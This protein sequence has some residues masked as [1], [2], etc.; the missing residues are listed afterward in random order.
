MKSK[1]LLIAAIFLSSATSK[2]NYD[3]RTFD[4]VLNGTVLNFSE[5]CK[6]P[7]DRKTRALSIIPT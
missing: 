4:S 3:L 7:F 1:L 6:L 5:S 2:S